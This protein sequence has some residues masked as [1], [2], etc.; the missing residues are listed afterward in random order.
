MVNMLVIADKVAD[1]LYS[2]NLVEG[3]GYFFGLRDSIFTFF[4]LVSQANEEMRHKDYCIDMDGLAGTLKDMLDAFEGEDYILLADVIE[5]RWVPVVNGL[6]LDIMMLSGI[7][8]R[9]I[10]LESNLDILKTV[11]KELFHVFEEAISKGVFI[12]DG[13]SMNYNGKRYTVEMTNQGLPTLSIECK[14]KVF[15]MHSNKDPIKDAAFIVNRYYSENT[16][17]YY[18]L[19][20]GLGY[21]PESFLDKLK[22]RDVFI[23]ERDLGVIYMAMSYRD[24]SFILNNS[25]LIYDTDYSRILDLYSDEGSNSTSTIL[26]HLPSIKNIEDDVLYKAINKLYIHDSAYR[27][28]RDILN[29]NFTSNIE[30]VKGSM[31]TVMT[32]LK[33]KKVIIV[34]GGPSLDKNIDDLAYLEDKEHRENVVIIATGTVYRKLL[35]KNIV[36]DYVIITDGKPHT[37]RQIDGLEDTNIPLILMS[38]A[39]KYIGIRYKGDKFVAFQQGYQK[40]V[41]YAKTHDEPLFATG[42]SVATT[43]LDIAIRSKAASI[44]FIGLDLAFTDNKNH[45]SDTYENDHMAI[46]KLNMIPAIGGGYVGTPDS[47]LGYKEW[48]EDRVTNRDAVMSI[49]DATEGGA[50]ISGFSLITLKEYLMEE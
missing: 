10:Y 7:E 18:I 1:N 28:I 42:G 31:K 40:A 49:Y 46:D 13:N 8:P 21:V 37:Y 14:D 41:N 35:K 2:Q 34:A 47:F 43:A 3:I 39:S 33:G 16:T 22:L 24:I 27:N 9:N 5:L 20:L 50:V 29:I 44:A 15:Y 32:K 12:N 38:T 23:Y 17:A 19:G 26:Y 30:N 6:M 25:K 36:A 45:A 48:M 4:D 11:N